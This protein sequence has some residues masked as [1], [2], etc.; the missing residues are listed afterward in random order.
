[1]SL[2]TSDEAAEVLAARLAKRGQINGG[3]LVREAAALIRA[4]LA[5]RT[6][7][8][9]SVV[10]FGVPWAVTHAR[11]HGLPPG[12]LVAGHYD[13]LARAGARMDG[14]TRGGSAA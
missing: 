2:D 7:L 11:A 5:E 3:E 14:F 12:Q 9:V 1:M 6:D 10:A 13:I 8:R 4:L